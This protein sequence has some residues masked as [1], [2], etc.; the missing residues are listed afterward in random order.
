MARAGLGGGYAVMM[1]IIMFT[2]H[3]QKVMSE[4]SSMRVQLFVFLFF[5]NLFFFGGCL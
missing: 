5:S 3:D 1:L 4:S 2:Y